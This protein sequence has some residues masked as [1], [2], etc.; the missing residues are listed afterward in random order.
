MGA[1]CFRT[2]T[3]SNIVHDPGEKGNSQVSDKFASAPCNISL[4]A[5]ISSVMK[6]WKKYAH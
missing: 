5:N 2:L 1:N 4:H 3:T 6:K